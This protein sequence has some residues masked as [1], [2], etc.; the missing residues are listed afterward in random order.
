[1]NDSAEAGRSDGRRPEG[2][3]PAVAAAL[4][5]AVLGLL[6][7][8]QAGRSVFGRV[9]VLDEVW[10]LDRA[11]DLQGLS[12]PADE[13]HFMSPLYP[14]L[15]KLAGSAH[16]VPEDRVVPPANLR[17]LRLLQL[18][19]WAGLLGLLRLLAGRLLPP[20]APRRRFL[21]WLPTLL[22]ALYRPAAVYA[23]AVLLELPLVFLV[24]LAL[25]LLT[26]LGA[27]RRPLPWA[28]LAGLALGLA[29]LLRGTALVLV[30]LAAWWAVRRAGCGR[31]RPIAAVVVPALLVLLPPAWHNSR[32]AGR[33]EG[34]A[35][36]GGVNLMIGNGPEA[37]GFYVAVIDGDWRA[38]PAGTEQ[39]A[40]ATGRDSLDLAA[41]DRIWTRRALDTM[42]SRP[43]RTVGLWLKKVWLHLQGWEIDQLT[44]L[45]GWT[46]TVPLLHLLVVPWALLVALGLTGAADLLA[47]RAAG[48]WTPVLAA[49]GL[50]LAVQSVFF[51]V[52]R[53][54]LALL[55]MLAL[56]AAAG[57]AALLSR[58]RVALVALPL[59]VLLTVP[60][61]LGPV[62]AQWRA[63]ALANEALRYNDLA[64][65]TD[66]PA[67]R[68]QAERLYRAA[69][70]AGAPGEAP[71]LGLAT[72][73]EAR[74]D[75]AAAGRVLAEGARLLPR[76]PGL[77]KSLAVRE[78]A[79]GNAAAAEPRLRAVLALR[80]RDAD[81]LHNLCVMLGG[82]ARSTP[83]RTWP[84]G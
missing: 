41:A 2:R 29:G 23:L 45:A 63:M 67:A 11:A 28:V 66:D 73:L 42:A 34:P 79:A 71:W 48:P 24:T 5:V 83:P 81:S 78:L 50:L 43:G 33:P 80:P 56:L 12:A 60:W 15:I 32:I 10:Y 17:G 3:L 14:V 51:V 72:V 31:W 38:D 19:C 82:G 18:G 26:D 40:A 35:L 69:L 76:A 1:M 6:L 30:P 21:V 64:A 36:N 8:G 54:R 77:Q 61:G 37:N 68:D 20:D 62:R 7:L 46:R 57:A 49:G 70:A 74:G 84:A 58:R 9:P 59:A 65:A 25:W 13:P 75:D 44:P 47:R 4:V 39:L 16:A 52:S 55:P 27:R 22:A 53:Y